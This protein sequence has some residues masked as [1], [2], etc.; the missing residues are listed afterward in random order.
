MF[1]RILSAYLKEFVPIGVPSTHI[2]EKVFWGDMN[3]TSKWVL[4]AMDPVL[5]AISSKGELPNEN[6]LIRIKLKSQTLVSIEG[7]VQ[8]KILFNN[9][10][11]V[12][13]RPVVTKI[14]GM[15][16]YEKWME[17][18]QLL[19]QSK[20]S[21]FKFN[22]NGIMHLAA[23]YFYPRKIFVVVVRSADYLNIFPM[24]LHVQPPTGKNYLL[25]L[26]PGNAAEKQLKM[27][28]KMVVCEIPADKIGYAYELGK[29]HG[30]INLREK[31]LPF[32]CTLSSTFKFP[33]PEFQIGYKEIEITRFQD[34]NTH[35]L[36][37]GNIVF[38]SPSPPD[39]RQPYH[40]HRFRYHYGLKIKDA[41]SLQRL[42]II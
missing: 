42:D 15:T 29:N 27:N 35:T 28:L 5:Y 22:R 32:N 30:Q 21:K 9:E 16:F 20:R 1:R 25:A 11:V 36:F 18:P 8:E 37:S 24:D 17:L 6:A 39:I 26:Q 10:M 33:L 23:S 34:L 13:W 40:I 2:E 41:Y 14:H 31:Q 3:I 19:R 12:L 38:E 4:V 7:D